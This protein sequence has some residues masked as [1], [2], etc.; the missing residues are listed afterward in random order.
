MKVRIYHCIEHGSGAIIPRHHVPSYSICEDI[1][2]VELQELRSSLPGKTIETLV[3]RGELMISDPDLVEGLSGRKVEN[4]YVKL[5]IV[6]EHLGG[7][8]KG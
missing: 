6:S 1:S 8:V 4:S 3:R 7:D 5:I 2:E